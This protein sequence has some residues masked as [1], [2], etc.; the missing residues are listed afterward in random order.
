MDGNLF[1]ISTGYINN[2][3]DK[4]NKYAIK[5]ISDD[6]NTRNS[7]SIEK[8]TLI[9]LGGE[10]DHK[11]S[12]PKNFI[13]FCNELYK[14]IT[15]KSKINI[16][17]KRVIGDNWHGKVA[18]KLYMDNDDNSKNKY[19]G[20]VIGSSNFTPINILND[21]FGWN[22]EADLYIVD[23]NLVTEST[24]LKI[25][26]ND[27]SLN[28]CEKEIITSKKRIKTSMNKINEKIDSVIFD[29][30]N[31]LDNL[32]KIRITCKDY[33]IKNSKSEHNYLF[34][35][36][37]QS[38]SN[39][40][41]FE[42]IEHEILKFVQ[43]IEGSWKD[44]KSITNRLIQKINEYAEDYH[45]ELKNGLKNIIKKMQ[46]LNDMKNCSYDLNNIY[47]T[48]NDVHKQFVVA[49][50]E[51]NFELNDKYIN[52]SN[53]LINIMADLRKRMLVFKSSYDLKSDG[54]Y[55]TTIIEGIYIGINDIIINFT[56][57]ELNL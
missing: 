21:Q 16:Q 12:Y 35:S 20:T 33:L 37:L 44:Y 48:L 7:R 27:L 31:T 45:N 30:L 5:Q 40:K 52:T 46:L 41:N 36:I 11:N 8:L 19:Y 49:T 1:I 34:Y 42:N 14:N 13:D 57:D 38:I 32:D 2:S 18:I 55:I 28:I 56:N 4:T 54:A 17:F 15:D 47:K 39:I 24:S 29:D 22:K 51:N 43:S 26:G 9:I 6:I 50:L 53:R 25:D 23:G 10:E 3:N